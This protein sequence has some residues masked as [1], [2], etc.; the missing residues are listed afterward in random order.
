M[1]NDQLNWLPLYWQKFIIGTLELSAEETGA[2]ILLLIHQWDKGFIP[3]NDKEIKKISRVSTKKL[4][5]VLEKFEKING[6]YYNNT[7]EII[8][9]EQQEK[10]DKNSN[11]GT[12]GAKARWDKHKLSIAQGLLKHCLEDSIREE[13]KREEE[14]HPKLI[15]EL[16]MEDC[17][18]KKDSL[19]YRIME[20][21]FKL[22]AGFKKIFPLNKDLDLIEMKEWIPYVR[23]L[24]EEK[25]YTYDNIRDVL[26]WAMEDKFWKTVIID[27]K[28]LEKNF[29]KLKIQY[30]DV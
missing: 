10:N 7:I 28:S 25:K 23:V 11:R 24:I 2:Y 17:K 16:R 5:K 22:F 6:K 12:K 9:I 14:K 21:S 3:E 27:A 15:C 18:L 29:E 20:S 30:Q 19:D 13:E 1:A 4:S 8:R 26:N